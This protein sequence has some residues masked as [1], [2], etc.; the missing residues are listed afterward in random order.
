VRREGE[1]TMNGAVS[2][3]RALGA[4]LLVVTVLLGLASFISLGKALGE[5]VGLAYSSVPS[6]PLD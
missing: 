5:A 4:A 6:D 1:H 3:R 2:T